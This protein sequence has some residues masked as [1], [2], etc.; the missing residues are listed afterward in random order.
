MNKRH[1]KHSGNS[2]GLGHLCQ[3][4]ETKTKYIFILY[5]S[6]EKSKSWLTLWLW[7]RHWKVCW[8]QTEKPWTP[9][10][11][12]KI[13]E[14]NPSIFVPR[15]VRSMY[16]DKSA[17]LPELPPEAT[18]RPYQR[19]HQFHAAPSW[20]RLSC[21]PGSAVAHTE[22]KAHFQWFPQPSRRVGWLLWAPR[23]R[24]GSKWPTRLL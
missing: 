1:H 15:V 8:I 16:V 3:E 14:K 18:P 19:Q 22:Y 11:E 7:T 24:G 12:G 4:L 2:K 20:V 9:D 5:H 6:K 17:E 23:Q 10:Q 13:K 21:Q